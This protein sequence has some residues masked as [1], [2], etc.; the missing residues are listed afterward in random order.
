[1][2]ARF[3]MMAVAGI[4]FTEV[5]GVEPKWFEAGARDYGAPL[6]ALIAVQAVI[7]GFLETKR[8]EG[9]KETGM[10]GVINSF[11][12]DPAGMNSKDMAL[13]EIKNGRLAMIAFVGFSVQAMLTGEGPIAGLVAHQSDP[14]GH[15]I[16]SNIVN[17][18]SFH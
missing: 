17:N 3:A 9:W 13:K 15:N 18:A 8:Y 7:M 12:F 2:N 6:P 4:L 1:M 14:L 16:T 11:P 5:T 10:S